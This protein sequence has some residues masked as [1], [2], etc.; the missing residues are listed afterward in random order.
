MAHLQN[1][2]PIE[3]V[4]WV[5]SL[6]TEFGG[7][8]NDLEVSLKVDGLGARFGKDKNDKF[9]FEGSRTGPIYSSSSFSEHAKSRGAEG[10]VLKRAEQYGE[11]FEDLKASSLWKS[12]PTDTKVVCEVFYNPMG[13][14]TADG[15]KFVSV[16]YDKTKLGSLM[17]IVPIQI[18][19][20]SSGTDH[21]DSAKILKTLYAASSSKIKVVDPKLKVGKI[22]IRAVTKP[23]TKYSDAEFSLIKSLKAADK[24]SK[25]AL[26]GT[27]QKAKDALAE[28]ILNHPAILGKDVLGKN[29]EGLVLKAGDQ[30]VKVTTQEFKDSKKPES[31]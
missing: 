30:A 4:Q 16:S 10:E 11:L 29:I 1:M 3:F 20:A 27:I 17:T 9:F 8:L 14:A 19:V 22:D 24:E 12:L 23:I 18:L 13:V 7:V 25:A 28:Y 26:I 2:K 31:K 21:K 15:V 5:Q 6:H